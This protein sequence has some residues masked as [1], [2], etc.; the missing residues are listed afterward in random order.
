MRTV[1][2]THANVEVA[3]LASYV[4]SQITPLPSGSKDVDLFEDAMGEKDDSLKEIWTPEKQ[5]VCISVHTR[6]L[7]RALSVCARVCLC[8]AKKQ[9]VCRSF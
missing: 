2:D 4:L 7:A 6:L 5:Q 1:R 9:M 3:G 8:G